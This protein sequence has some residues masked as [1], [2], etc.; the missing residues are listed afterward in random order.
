MTKI[1]IGLVGAG[2]MSAYH[3]AGFRKAGAF[4]AAVADPNLAT[5]QAC[6]AREGVAKV[7]AS[8]E[9]MLAKEPLDAVSVLT[10]NKF[11]ASVTCAALAAGKH[12]F[13]EKPP[14]LC[15]RDTQRMAQAA[16]R[17]GKLL[18]FDFC[19][20]ARPESMALKKAIDAGEVGT[21]NSAQAAWIRRTGI[22]GFGGWFTNKALSGGGPVIDLLHAADLAMYFMGFPEPAWVLARTYDD[23]IRD[24]R[25]RGPWGIPTRENGTC[26]VE[27]ASHAL[28]TFRNGA[29]LFLRNSWAEM[30]KREESGVVFQG[31]KAGGMIKRT[32][33]Q[34]GIDE[35]A[36]D[37]AELYFQDARGKRRDKTL[38]VK[39][40]KAMGRI[41]MA[42]NFIQAL[43]GKAEPISKPD[44]AVKLMK[45]V[46][47]IYASAQRNA[48]VRIRA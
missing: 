8:A 13:C 22:P 32:F 43:Q 9:E 34:D 15:A 19:N 44:E 20:R 35:T 41:T 2:G 38:K 30:I 17:A 14:A 3:I 1:R 25:F 45:V 23:F 37:V 16:A 26:D 7:Y 5:A 31:T 40:D 6:A 29:A 21:I 4:V 24:P 33:G 28:V 11:H 46:D 12:V 27:A 36:T 42:A 18:M 39:P 47:A 48:P 10:P